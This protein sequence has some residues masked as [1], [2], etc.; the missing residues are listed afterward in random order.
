[1][2]RGPKPKKETGLPRRLSLIGRKYYYRWSKNRIMEQICLGPN[3]DH[4]V[5]IATKANAILDAYTPYRIDRRNIR[6]HIFERDGNRCVYCGATE[7]LSIDH[8][9]PLSKGGTSETRNLV[10][11]CHSCNSAKGNMPEGKFRRS[12]SRT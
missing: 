2:I 7:R 10:T 11:A 5:E 3:R 8:K 4:A 6:P 9:V 1:M 12:D